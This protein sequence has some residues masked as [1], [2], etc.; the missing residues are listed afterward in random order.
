MASSI[1]L[2]HNHPGGTLKA[3]KQDILFTKKINE[4][5]K[6]FNINLLD[7]IIIANNKFISMKQLEYI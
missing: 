1:I 7:H 4:Y 3:S 6:V 5:S 2:C